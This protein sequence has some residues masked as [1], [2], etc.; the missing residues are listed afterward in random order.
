MADDQFQGMDAETVRAQLGQWVP[1]MR[2]RAIAWL[3]Q[4]D[5]DRREREDASNAEQ[6]ALARAA[7]ALAERS[8]NAAQTS[9]RIAVVAL[10]VAIIAMVASIIGL[11]HTEGHDSQAK[12]QAAAAPRRP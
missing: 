7:S 10:I 8:A 6:I 12:A 5:R 9:N 3:A 4:H 11:V 1:D 2:S